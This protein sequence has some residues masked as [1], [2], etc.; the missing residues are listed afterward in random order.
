MRVVATLVD[1]MVEN[2]NLNNVQDVTYLL[3]LMGYHTCY[4]RYTTLLGYDVGTMAMGKY[5]VE[6][7]KGKE[8]DSGEYVT[9]HTYYYRWRRDFP[10]LKTA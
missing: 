8:V 3:I 1:G 6:G 7:E 4:K 9:F 2:A 10:N 5:I